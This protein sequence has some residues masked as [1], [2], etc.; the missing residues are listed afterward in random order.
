MRVAWT[1][2]S[3]LTWRLDSFMELFK[4][5]QIKL[6]S[7]NLLLWTSRR[8]AVEQMDLRLILLCTQNFILKKI[9]NVLCYIKL[10]S[11]ATVIKWVLPGSGNIH[12]ILLLF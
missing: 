6:H 3:L 12:D 7:I 4:M 2:S 10:K 8:C 5:K 9:G 11:G 1:P